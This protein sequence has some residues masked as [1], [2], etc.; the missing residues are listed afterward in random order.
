M[1]QRNVWEYAVV[2]S[3]IEFIP[4]AEG[5]KQG[6]SIQNSMN[7]ALAAMGI[8]YG[9]D[10]R[11][12]Y[13]VWCEKE[14]RYLE[15]LTYKMYEEYCGENPDFYNENRPLHIYHPVS[16]RS[17]MGGLDKENYIAKKE[18]EEQQ[19]DMRV[20]L[21]DM[22]LIAEEQEIKKRELDAQELSYTSRE[23]GLNAKEEMLKHKAEE[24][25]LEAEANKQARKQIE[26]DNAAAAERNAILIKGFEELEEEKEEFRE[27]QKRKNE[28]FDERV[29]R[30]ADKKVEEILDK[31]DMERKKVR[32]G[33]KIYNGSGG[34]SQDYKN[35]ISGF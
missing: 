14:R 28:E 33:E 17:R 27:Y 15:E 11:C 7:K 22:N 31:M 30:A 1:N 6:L 2:H 12:P 20:A 19:A 21:D 29:N 3:H 10:R 24:S 26:A 13:E 16:D 9:K 5:F 34:S 32:M 8:E 4:F 18:L 35:I 25:K 23:I